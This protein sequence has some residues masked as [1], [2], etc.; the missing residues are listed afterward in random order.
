[1]RL[2]KTK[3]PL[4]A[5]LLFSVLISV[6]TLSASALEYRDDLKIKVGLEFG[7]TSPKQAQFTSESGF[8]IISFDES[9]YAEEILFETAQTGLTVKN[10]SGIATVHI[11]DGTEVYRS[12]SET[13]YIAGADGALRYK[14]GTYLDVIKIFC[15][16]GL[17]RVINIVEFEKYIKGVLPREIYPSWPDEA[18]KTAAIVARTFGF[19]SL[20]G[21]HQKYGVDVCTTSC[22]QVFGGNGENEHPATNAAVDATKNIIL[23]YN[24]KVAMAVYTSSAGMHTESSFGA[25]GGDQ[26]QHPYLAGVP[27]F[28]ETP[29]EYPRGTWSGTYSNEEIL[30]YINSK[31]AYAGKLKGVIDSIVLEYG[32]TGYARKITV[33]DIYGS[34][35]S[36]K[37]SDNVR[38]MISKF[39]RS[40]CVK[41]VPNYDQPTSASVLTADGIKT[42]TSLPASS[43][44]LRADT[45]DTP[46]NLF[47]ITTSPVSFTISG[48]GWGHGVGLSQFGAMTLA[49]SGCTYQQIL[50]L[51]YPG[52]YFTTPSG[53]AA[54]KAGSAQ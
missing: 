40:A 2:L 53:L 37:N 35:V 48:T 39:V 45:G 24:G 5:L 23:A 4:F 9:T 3:R 36:A 51:Y 8:K 11:S 22:C 42:T 18:L 17:M 26:S 34:S 16:D 14:D 20:G 49:K 33:T 13:L 27:T 28:H 44:V 15:K 31:S 10:T 52:T 54:E 32:E 43:Y 41:I 1:M 38:G 46:V 30:A 50:A 19:Y 25:W 29:E 12:E 21:K 6:F 47:E 7:T